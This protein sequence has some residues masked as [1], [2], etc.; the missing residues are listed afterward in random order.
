MILLRLARRIGLTFLAVTLMVLGG[1]SALAIW[2]RFDATEP[3]RDLLAGMV[4]LLCR[5]VSGNVQT[6]DCARRLCRFFR[7]HACVVVHR[8]AIERPRLAA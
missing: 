8:H 1:W 2:F 4:V 7:R 5:S 3:V 6:M